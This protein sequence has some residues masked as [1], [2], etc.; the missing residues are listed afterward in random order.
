MSETGAQQT[1]TS[2]RTG[3]RHGLRRGLALV[4]VAVLALTATAA[5]AQETSESG[6]DPLAHLRLRIDSTSDW[7]TADLTGVTVVAADLADST[8]DDKAYLNGATLTVVG[9]APSTASVE[10]LVRVSEQT[11]LRLDKG[12]DGEATATLERLGDDPAVITT[13]DNALHHGDNQVVEADLDPAELVGAGVAVPVVDDRK[14]T[15]AF[16]YPW[17]NA[18]TW[19][20]RPFMNTP[21]SAWRT[22]DPHH[23]ETMVGQAAGAGVNGFV[24]SFSDERA[25][26]AELDLVMDAAADHDAFSVA[27]LLELM[28]H[29]HTGLLGRTRLDVGSAA[30]AARAALARAQDPNHLH[31]GDRPVLAAYGV[32]QVPAEDWDRLLAALDDL[33]PFVL[34]D[35]TDP[36]RGLDGVYLYD[37]TQPSDSALRERYAHMH[38][39]THLAPIVVDDLPTRLFAATVAPGKGVTLGTLT[40]HRSREGGARYD[41]SWNTATGAS[42]EWILITSWNE[43]YESTQIAPSV[44]HGWKALEQTSTWTSRF[45]G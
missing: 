20:G 6:Q 12:Y 10:L 27:P 40:H 15:L 34:G 33:D 29:T 26:G 8:G 44:E 9:D 13:L 14:L 35:S 31:V 36:A 37:P 42:P 32:G 43:W 22:D 3:T 1:P 25:D 19:Q 24:V 21:A 2:T 11:G 41:R 4:V 38:W 45:G 18:D 7:T 39:A 28:P 16:Y 17:W 23:V 5:R 30:A